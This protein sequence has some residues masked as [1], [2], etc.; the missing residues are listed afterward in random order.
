MKGSPIISTLIA[1]VIMLGLYALMQVGLRQKPVSTN[2]IEVDPPPSNMVRVFAEIYFATP[3]ESFSITHPTTGEILINK[4][5]LDS[6]EWSGDLLVPAPLDDLEINVSA[7][8]KSHPGM[9]FMQ[10]TLSPNDRDPASATLRSESD[11][12]TT[13]TF[14]W[15][16][17]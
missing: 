6:T 16:H 7:T 4:K 5:N 12:D 2:L 15:H 3:P 14:H 13:A 1:T 8:W 9:Q 10:I 11:I 17:H